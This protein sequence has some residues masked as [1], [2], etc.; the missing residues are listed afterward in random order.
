MLDFVRENIEG[1][2]GLTG[3]NSMWEKHKDLFQDAKW[4][5]ADVTKAH[6]AVRAEMLGIEAVDEVEE[7]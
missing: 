6:K 1:P 7:L 2:D 5:K 4:S 3:S